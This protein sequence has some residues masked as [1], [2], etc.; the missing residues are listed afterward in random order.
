MM[1]L[2]RRV[3][4]EF[5][6][7]YAC[8]RCEGN[9]GEAVDQAGKLCGEVE[10]VKEFTYLGDRVSAGGGCE[11]VVTART[12]CGCVMFRLFGELLYGRSFPLML[13][14]AV[15]GSYVRPV[16]LYGCET[17]CL[18]ESEMGILQRTERSMVRAMFGIQLKDRKRSK[19]LMLMLDLNETMDNLAMANS[20]C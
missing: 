11:A 9:I 10:T 14:G 1:C 2:S 20:V 8:R 16:M 15:N 6:R 3:A 13:K 19:D 7:N 5:S 4:P 17:W 18:K 12:R